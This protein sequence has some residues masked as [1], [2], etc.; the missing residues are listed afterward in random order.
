MGSMCCSTSPDHLYFFLRDTPVRIRRSL[1]LPSMAS[2]RTILNF[3]SACR[4]R[5][6]WAQTPKCV[7]WDHIAAKYHI[8][9]TKSPLL[10][11][12]EIIRMHISE[13]CRICNAPRASIR[14][15][16]GMRCCG[17][18]FETLTVPQQALKLVSPLVHEDTMKSA[19]TEWRYVSSGNNGRKKKRELVYFLPDILQPQNLGH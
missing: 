17:R 8:L 16:M 12:S 7:L 5:F 13:K 2:I 19:R 1:S 4:A 11:T 14:W 9:T 3:I 15:G 10:H 6:E 18:C